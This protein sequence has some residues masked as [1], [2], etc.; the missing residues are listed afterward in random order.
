LN[1]LKSINSGKLKIGIL[2]GPEGGLEPYEVDDL[3]ANGA[4]SVSL[5]K[6]ILRTE[7]A[8]FTAVTIAQYIMG[9]FE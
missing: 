1:A 9:E 3:Q 5:G 7:T 4:F 6:R 2:V 8:G